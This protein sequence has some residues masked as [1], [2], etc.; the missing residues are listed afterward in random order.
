MEISSAFSTSTEA[1]RLSK[2]MTYSITPASQ[3]SVILSSLAKPNASWDIL[4]SS[5][6]IVVLRYTNATSKR[7]P[8]AV[9]MTQWPFDCYRDAALLIFFGC[10]CQPL[11]LKCCHPLPLLCQLSKSLGADHGCFRVLFFS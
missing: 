5:L 8:L 4:R 6:K 10:C 11:P 2:H 3:R 7:L 1:F 9:Y